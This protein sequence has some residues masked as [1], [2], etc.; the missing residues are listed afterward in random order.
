MASSWRN[1][2]WRQSEMFSS[3]SYFSNHTAHHDSQLFIHTIIT[4]AWRSVT[5]APIFVLRH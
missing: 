1:A 3:S 4:V 2:Y 5:A